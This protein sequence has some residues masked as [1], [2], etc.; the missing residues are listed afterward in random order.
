MKA[1]CP[2][3]CSHD[4]SCVA[5]KVAVHGPTMRVGSTD[6]IDLMTASVGAEKPATTSGGS[7]GY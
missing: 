5:T 4:V 2:P 7:T 1:P 3:P 6:C